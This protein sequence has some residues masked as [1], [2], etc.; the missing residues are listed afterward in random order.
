MLHEKRDSI[1]WVLRL[2]IVAFTLAT[3]YIH[4]T[5]GG[6][7]FIANAAL[8]LAFAVLMSL[9]LEI[10]SRFRWL[11]RLALILFAL[12]TIVGWVM[13][14]AR[15]WTGYLDKAIEVALIALLSVE[16]VRYDGGPMAVARR[17]LDLAIATLSRLTGRSAA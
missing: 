5:L 11:V 14:G 17:A 10:A 16:M 4:V 1:A 3:A 6:T 15:Y 8:Y 9:P 7:M 13:F 12:A 2:A